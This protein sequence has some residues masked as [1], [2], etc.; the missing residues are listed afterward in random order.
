MARGQQ[1][2]CKRTSQ[3]MVTACANPLGV[4]E[5]VYKRVNR[6]VKTRVNEAV[7]VTYLECGDLSPLWISNRDAIAEASTATNTY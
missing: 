4:N 5:R 1:I 7:E 3:M 6:R 2:G